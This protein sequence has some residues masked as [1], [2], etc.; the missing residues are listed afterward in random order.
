[1]ESVI[2][3]YTLRRSMRQEIYQSRKCSVALDNGRHDKPL[4]VKVL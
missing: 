4:A 1:M 2:E 3:D